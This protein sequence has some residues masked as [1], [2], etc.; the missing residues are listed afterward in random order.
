MSSEVT[1]SMRTI[2]RDSRQQIVEIIGFSAFLRERRR[3][4]ERHIRSCEVA[5][6][7]TQE[8][9][10]I[11]RALCIMDQQERSALPSV[12]TLHANEAGQRLAKMIKRQALLTFADLAQATGMAKY[13]EHNPNDGLARRAAYL[14]ALRSLEL[15]GPRELDELNYL[16]SWQ[17]G[18]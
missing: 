4:L 10:N 2:E 18:R 17:D 7:E 6:R 1:R 3:F 11:R 12:D 14:H 13:Q 15:A 9:E 8:L 16:Q 5:A